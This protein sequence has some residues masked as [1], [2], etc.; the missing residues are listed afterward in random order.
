[1]TPSRSLLIVFALLPM[2]ATAQ[3]SA[4]VAHT[5]L[6]AFNRAFE[7]ATRHMD[8]TATL[9]LWAEKGVS[10]LPSTSPIVGKAAIAKFLEKVTGSLRGA[11]MERFEMR[12]FDI[13]VSGDWA[14]EWCTE[15]QRVELGGG[16]PPFEGWGKMLLVLHRDADGT[17]RLKQEMWNQAT[18]NSTADV[19]GN[20]PTSQLPTSRFR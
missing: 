5:K 15:H 19:P 4:R 14:S 8:N 18:P 7:D 6:D 1:M 16:K 12:C 2:L 11:R 13:Q 9:A 20:S 10:L 3:P 17:W